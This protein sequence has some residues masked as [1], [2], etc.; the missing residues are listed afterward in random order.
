[1]L[2]DSDNW[3]DLIEMSK[4]KLTRKRNENLV[5]DLHSTGKSIREATGLRPIQPGKIRCLQCDQWFN[6]WDIVLNRRC[7]GCKAEDDYEE[8]YIEELNEKELLD[9]TLLDM[10]EDE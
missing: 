3:R 6:A 10:E 8:V 4:R 7:D 9:T 1:M 5:S 2:F